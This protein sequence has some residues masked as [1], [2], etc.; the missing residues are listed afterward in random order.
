MIQ[1]HMEQLSHSEFHPF[2]IKVQVAFHKEIAV[3]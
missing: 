1:F 2:E 3:H